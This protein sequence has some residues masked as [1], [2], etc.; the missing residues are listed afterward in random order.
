MWRRVV[1]PSPDLPQMAIDSPRS[2]SRRNVREDID[3]LGRAEDLVMLRGAQ[4]HSDLK[5]EEGRMRL[6]LMAG[7]SPAA[8]ERN[9]SG[10]EDEEE[11]FIAELVGR[12]WPKK[13]GLK[14][15]VPCKA[16]RKRDEADRGGRRVK[17][18]RLPPRRQLTRPWRCRKCRRWPRCS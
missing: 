3:C 5:T 17:M 13:A 14:A 18:A 1:F 6:A 9:G 7:I 15:A 8:R 16:L 10:D 2:T 12:D 4:D 11:R